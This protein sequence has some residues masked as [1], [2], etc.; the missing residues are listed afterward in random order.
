ML[1]YRIYTKTS[2]MT[3]FQQKI[4]NFLNLESLGMAYNNFILMALSS[5]LGKLKKLKFL[6][7][8]TVN[9][10]SAIRES[11]TNLSSL[12]HLDFSSNNLNNSIPFELLS[13]I[14]VFYSY[15][16]TNWFDWTRSNSISRWINW[17]DQ[18]QKISKIYNSWRFWIYIPRWNPTRFRYNSKSEDFYIV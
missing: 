7:M 1:H 14:W 4:G 5:E 16:R 2:S 17:L 18:Y 6:W 3:H 12:D 8:S 13:L 9:L 11:F 15:I 10:I